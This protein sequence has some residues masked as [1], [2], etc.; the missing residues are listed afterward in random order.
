MKLASLILITSFVSSFAFANE[1]A[2]PKKHAIPTNTST[3]TTSPG[4][5]DQ[6]KAMGNQATEKALVNLNTAPL[7]TLEKVPG[8]T[9]DHAKQIVANRPYKSVTELSKI[10]GLKQDLI[11]KIKPYVTAD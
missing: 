3:P 7:A 5:I 6:A 2:G 11:A 4:M 1:P 9:P 10:K 8:L